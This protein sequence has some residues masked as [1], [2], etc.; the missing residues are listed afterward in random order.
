MTKREFIHTLRARLAGLPPKEAW[1]RLDFYTEAIE[2]RIEEGCSEEEAV[3]EL[4]SVDEIATQIL[5][6]IPLSALVKDK[7]KPR[8]RLRAWE[9]VLLAVGSPIWASLLIAVFAVL[10]SLYAVL[11]SVIVAIWAVDV[12][13]G[14]CFLGG[15]AA[16]VL[17]FVVGNSVS[18][19]LMIGVGLVSAGLSIFLFFGCLQATKGVL[20]LTGK[21][22]LG[23]KRCF[24]RKE[25]ADE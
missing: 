19:L 15:I 14:A 6:D 11:W 17:F 4:G 3:A 5:A 21:I 25:K 9:I 12:S 8:R 7:I 10:I 16:G 2:D 13:L 20:W 1:E 22:V 23:I 18:G 24:V